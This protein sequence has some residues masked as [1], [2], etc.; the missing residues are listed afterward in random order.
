[1]LLHTVN[2]SPF[3]RNSFA[4]CMGHAKKGSSVLL[5]E[6]GV[7]AALKGAANESVVSNA[8]GD[9]GVYVLGPDL[10]ARGMTDEDVI[11]GVKIV[12]YTGFVELA[13]EHD[14]VQSWL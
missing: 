14:V 12:D 11:D 9:I 5:I 6:D 13:A 8:I 1:M 10:N 7:F 3:E 4:Q 2:K